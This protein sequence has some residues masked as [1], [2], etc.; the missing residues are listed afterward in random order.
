MKHL[1]FMPALT[2][3][4]LLA[5]CGG[6]APLVASIS[7]VASA[8]ITGTVTQQANVVT[9]SLSFKNSGTAALGYAL[10]FPNQRPAW[11]TALSATSGTVDAGKT[12]TIT[13]SAQ[14]PVQP[15]ATHTTTV[16]IQ[17]TGAAANI[18][19]NVT[20][21]LACTDE[22]APSVTATANTV[23]VTSASD[24][25]T[26]TAIAA[27]NVGVQRVEFWQEGQDAPFATL[28]AA[29]SEPNTYAVTLPSYT[30][31]GTYKYYV[32]AYDAS[33][34]SS[35]SAVVEVVV[36]LPA[37]APVLSDGGINVTPGND[38]T[39]GVTVTPDS[40]TV[41]RVAYV[42]KNASG[43]TVHEGGATGSGPYTIPSSGTKLAPGSYSVTI[44][45]YNADDVV[46]NT[47]TKTFVVPDYVSPTAPVVTLASG[48][49]GGYVNST[50]VTFT[51]TTFDH[52]GISAFGYSLDGG[53]TKHDATFTYDAATGT[54]TVTVTGLPQGTSSLLIYAVDSTDA[55]NVSDASTAVQVKVD[56]AAPT[57]GDIEASPNTVVVPGS[58]TLSVPASDATSGVASVM[59]ERAGKS[60]TATLDTTSNTWVATENFTDISSDTTFTYTAT[61]TDAAGNS[62]TSTSV[63]VTVKRPA[64]PVINDLSVTSSMNGASRNA[65]VSAIITHETPS[66][67]VVVLYTAPGGT[68]KEYGPYNLTGTDFKA[69]IQK[70]EIGGTVRLKVTDDVS[71]VYSESVTI[72]P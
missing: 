57:V 2:L 72:Q 49:N 33:G 28:T 35:T 14:C 60:L 13:F 64:A 69:T 65:S 59:F 7:N 34:K 19:Q 62:A 37:P 20:L 52:T 10:S 29:T 16:K 63:N 23:T 3:P 18:S 22:L 43:A 54:Y 41:A 50:T 36:N 4:L 55:K 61:V 70:V 30:S 48:T 56:S 67:Q 66:V 11:I 44:T 47:V 32:K 8:P 42:I 46:S 9:G 38:G 58:V 5:A 71:T 24:T 27:D 25:V 17:G 53:A 15:N 12:E 31:N 45:A 1:R 21:T 6:G 68:I 26:I 39:A 40:G 51:A